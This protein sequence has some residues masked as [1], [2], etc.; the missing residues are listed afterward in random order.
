MNEHAAAAGPGPRWARGWTARAKVVHVDVEASLAPIRID[1]R[2]DY[3]LLIVHS[4]RTMVGQIR[5]ETP[6]SRELTEGEL[7][8]SI[9]QQLGWF[10]WRERF[11]RLLQ[12]R[13]LGDGGTAVPAEARVSVIV[14]TRDRPD[15]LRSCLDALV[16]LERQADEIIVVDNCPSD[17]RTEVLCRSYEVR[18]VREPI[19]GQ[20]R[21]RNRGI[22]ESRGDLIAFTDDDCVPDSHW[23]DDLEASFIDPLVMA[24]TGYVGPVELETPAQL[25]FETH[26]GFGRSTER[27]I[28]DL[29]NPGVMAAATRAGAGANM[30]FRRDVFRTVGMFAEDLGP[31]TPARSGDDKYY[32]FK[33]VRLGYRICQEPTR[34]VWHRHRDDFQALARIMNDY[35]VAEFAFATRCIVAD[36]ELSAVRMW[37]WWGTHFRHDFVAALRRRDRRIPI[38]LTLAELSGAAVGPILMLR[39]WWSR[40]R[41]R[42]VE[43]PA[44]SESAS[45]RVGAQPI[46]VDELPVSSVIIPTYNRRED[47][48]E[49]LDALAAQDYPRDRFEVVVI[50]DGST[51]G[52]AEM[53]RVAD[54]PYR[55]HLVEQA[56]QGVAIARNHGVRVAKGNLLVFLDDDIRPEP[57]FLHVH[58]RAHC[59]DRD[60]FVLGY[61][62]P[63]GPAEGLLAI[64]LRNWWEDHYRLKDQPGHPWTFIDCSEGNVSLR[65][66][67]FLSLGGYDENFPRNRADWEFGVRLLRTGAN[68][69]FR[70]DAKAWHHY[71]PR[72]DTTL[73]K[74]REAGRMDVRL[75]RKHP[76]IAGLL[77]LA[78]ADSL[79]GTDVGPSTRTHSWRLDAANHLLLDRK[80]LRPWLAVLEWMR[81]RRRWSLCLNDLFVRAYTAGVLEEVSDTFELHS[82][83]GP[84]REGLD[85]TL[86]P[87]WLDRD[88]PFELPPDPGRVAIAV[89]QNGSSWGMEWAQASGQWDWD[90]VLRAL[91]E[92]LAESAQLRFA[93]D[94]IAKAGSVGM[95]AG[96]PIEDRRSPNA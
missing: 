27:R 7:W 24:V 82:L 35:G 15:Q 78:A 23:L 69:V 54:V 4:G 76:H 96:L 31:G 18:Y 86:V 11:Q 79:T 65:R 22:V 91:S 72:L 75:A 71:N 25:L 40:R 81:L 84:I 92:T 77:P 26:Y 60:R 1:E 64:A 6:P 28:L 48:R 68:F 93:L 39:S 73:V 13:I 10:I 43:L 21:A 58:G 46:E 42:S 17:P 38:R 67:F 47:L 5:V 94:G 74:T 29:N 63:A 8:T 16:A 56:N 20:A 33:I 34:Q 2:Y 70:R 87:V 45:V 88:D 83:L 49:V 32:F 90:R 12:T 95:S 89:G 50:D 37:L 30:I 41:I 66:G 62:P 3:V 14:C 9:S 51:D 59:D 44:A 36:R 52:T 80:I 61:C 85:K 55:I 53:V 19:P 57:Q